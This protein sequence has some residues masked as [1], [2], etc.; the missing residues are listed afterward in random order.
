[1]TGRN[2]RA[3]RAVRRLPQ[4]STY[5]WQDV[6]EGT[7]SIYSVERDGHID[8]I[9]GDYLIEAD[10]ESW[11]EQYRAYRQH[12]LREGRPVP[13]L[14]KPSLRDKV[15]VVFGPEVSAQ[16]AVAALQRAIADIT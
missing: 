9:L 1:M 16:Q 8:Y 4:Q 12:R 11:P 14:R 15:L 5:Q 6:F 7:G 2:N 3:A 10:P 13:K